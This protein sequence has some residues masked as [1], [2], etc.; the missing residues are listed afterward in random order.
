MDVVG[1]FPFRLSI[2]LPLFYSCILFFDLVGNVPIFTDYRLRRGSASETGQQRR[3]QAKMKTRLHYGFWIVAVY[4][5][6]VPCI[7]LFSNPIGLYM[8]PICEELGVPQGVY[9]L[10]RTFTSVLC[11]GSYIFY[12]PLQ[13]RFGVRILICMGIFSGVLSAFFYS[14]A[15]NLAMIFLAAAFSAFINPLAH[16]VSM[17]NMVNAWFAKRNA[18][19]LSVI[20]ACGNLGGFFNAKLIAYW[21]SAYGWRNSMRNTMFILISI[22]VVAFLVL[23]DTLDRVLGLPQRK[24]A[25]PLGME[26]PAAGPEEGGDPPELPGARFRIRGITPNTAAS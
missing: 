19:I 20:F 2:F 18:T 7:F 4:C 12:V 6:I 25:A 23:R 15:G 9:S 26:T 21:I 1:T 16:Q 8:V 11:A 14:T 17:G 5:L 3:S 13:K 10:S 24:G 22:M